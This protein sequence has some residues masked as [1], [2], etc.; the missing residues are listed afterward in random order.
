MDYVD[1]ERNK[2]EVQCEEDRELRAEQ[3]ENHRRVV[4]VS[5]CSEEG[6]KVLK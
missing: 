4:C 3:P 6:V 1:G 2:A 5:V